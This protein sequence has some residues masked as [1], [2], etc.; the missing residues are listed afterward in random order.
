M[1]CESGQL[2][3]DSAEIEWDNV[4]L[5]SLFLLSVGDENEVSDMTNII[6]SYLCDPGSL[7]FYPWTW[8]IVPA[9]GMTVFVA[10]HYIL[11]LIHY[12][13][14]YLYYANVNSK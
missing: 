13:V 7:H 8:I 14:L 6:L 9:S 12:T 10:L 11:Y 2:K 1:I 3:K 5:S 4:F